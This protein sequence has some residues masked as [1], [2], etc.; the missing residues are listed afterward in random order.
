MDICSIFSLLK[1]IDTVFADGSTSSAISLIHDE[2]SSFARVSEKFNIAKYDMS[3]AK[4]TE[5]CSADDTKEDILIYL[6]RIRKIL[7]AYIEEN[8]QEASN[9]FAIKGAISALINQLNAYLVTVVN[10]T[11]VIDAIHDFLDIFDNV[12][13][14]Y[15]AN[16]KAIRQID[17]D[18]II[19]FEINMS[20]VLWL[21]ARVAQG[22]Q[23]VIG[24]APWCW[25]L[26]KKI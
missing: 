9:I 22:L 5:T 7:D 23:M 20:W 21:I 11:S 24:K 14:F 4:Y 12:N 8:A 2:R 26:S 1:R 17:E 6:A 15:A 10:T 16:F 19:D 3:F 25:L 13:V 18:Q